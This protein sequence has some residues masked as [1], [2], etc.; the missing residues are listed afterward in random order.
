MEQIFGFSVNS[1]CKH[2]ETDKLLTKSSSLVLTYLLVLGSHHNVI[3]P[4]NMI[5]GIAN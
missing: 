4:R 5:E 3:K 2:I 1:N